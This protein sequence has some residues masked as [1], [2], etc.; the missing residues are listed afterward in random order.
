MQISEVHLF[1]NSLSETEFFYKEK[2]GFK[3]M[4][5]SDE[6]LSFQIGDSLLYFHLS[7]AVQK[8]VYHFAFDIPEN[9]L[10]EGLEWIRER[11][12]LIP[13]E[14]HEIIDFSNWHAKSFYFYDNNGNILECIVRYDLKHTSEAIFNA[15]SF[16]KISEIGFV[17]DNVLRF[18]DAVNLEYETDYF[19]MQP[20]RENF[21]V[22]G[23]NDGLFIVSGEN[24]NWFPT[25]NQAQPFWTKVVFENNGK[26][27]ILEHLSKM[28]DSINDGPENN[29]THQPENSSSEFIPINDTEST[30][31]NQENENMEVHK[32][33]HHVTHKKKWKEYLLEFFMIFLAVFLGFV[34]ENVR[35][36]VIEHHR[37]KEFALSLVKD[38]QNDMASIDSYRKSS[39]LYIATADSLLN[40]NKKP[41]VNR[42]AAKFSFY[43]RFMYWTVPHSWNRATFEQIKNSGSLRYFKNYQLLEKIMKYD[44]LVNEIEGEYKNHQTRGNMVLNQINEIID[45][46]VHRDLSKYM[47]MQFDT[48]S[49]GTKERYFSAKTESLEDKR[50]EIKVLLNIVIVQQRNLRYNDPKLLKT[51]KLASELINDLKKEYTIQ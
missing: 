8:P 13:F 2:L 10:L 6:L 7:S 38:L 51:K 44:A 39:A 45:P 22:L 49:N 27:Y 37:S 9:K 12:E 42:N 28:T 18:C 24:R 5:K 48:I 34:A 4:E 11:A 15:D 33:P 20:K 25:M 19:V 41:L 47:I 43:T 46:E 32:H 29:A 16:I 31:L 1:T 50:K 30:L 21:S 14:T 23:D 3:V 36:S 17:V 35:E 40:L 26:Q